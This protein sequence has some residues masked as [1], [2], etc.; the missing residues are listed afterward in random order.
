MTNLALALNTK[1]VHDDILSMFK[2]FSR[3]SYHFMQ[4]SL[5]ELSRSTHEILLKCLIM[6]GG[7]HDKVPFVNLGVAKV[8]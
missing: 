6:K 4:W 3:S 2:K 5:I 7:L 8:F 1:V